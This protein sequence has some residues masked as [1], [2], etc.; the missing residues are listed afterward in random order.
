MI[1][2]RGPDVLVG[3]RTPLR[4]NAVHADG[5][6][7]AHLTKRN[8]EEQGL[9]RTL[10]VVGVMC[11]ALMQTLDS[12][13]INVALPYIQ[14]NLGAT[15][16]QATWVATGFIVANVIVIPLTPWLSR[17][18]GRKRYFAISI[19]G[20]T[21]ASVACGLAPSLGLL[22]LAR[23]VQGAFGGGLL[24]VA[25]PILIDTFPPE[26]LGTS[27]GIFTIGAVFGPALG[28]AFGGVLTDNL[29]WR[30]VFF[31]N[32]PFGILALTLVL[33]YLK[34]PQ[35]AEHVPGDLFG[36][37]LLAVGVFGV[38]YVLDEGERDDWFSNPGIVASAIAGVAGYIGFVIW[39]LY[40]TRTPIVKLSVFRNRSVAFGSA[41]GI[42]LGV[43][44][45]GATLILPQYVS[46]L[47]GFTATLSGTLILVRAVPIA[48]VTP[49]VGLLVQS[50]KIDPRIML[51]TGVLVTG[52]GSI[53][54]AY[55]TTSGADFSTF[56]APLIVQGIGCGMLFVPLLFSVL[57]AVKNAEDRS[58]VSAFI[59]LFFQ[60]GGSIAAA[61]LVTLL[62]QRQALHMDTLSGLVTLSRAPIREALASG[63]SPQQIAE[64]LSQ[65]V[66]QQSLAFAFAD[67]FLVI[68]AATLLVLPL[69]AGLPKPDTAGVAIEIG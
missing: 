59:N 34:D 50:G 2:R 38:Q 1:D 66:T 43:P 14:G 67:V 60:L 11:A 12:T 56:V 36:I 41:I 55:T 37:V 51:A 26:Q 18:L 35:D 28:P 69:I 40:G 4:D 31:I 61:T 15:I 16:D 21:G 22:I 47:L 53:W 8:V 44:L 13:I 29:D 19:V 42:V 57:G 10:V 33:L 17:R 68:G 54:Q 46:T 24:A 30:W 23:V 63:R 64:A 6:A 52:V 32:V 27:Q 62:D 7:A 65:L 5:N 49:L 45:F 39:E 20:F 58:A 48:L 3:A 9:R 25:Q